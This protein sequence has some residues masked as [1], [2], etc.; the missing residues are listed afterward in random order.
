M[1][2]GAGGGTAQTEGPGQL[3]LLWSHL[4]MGKDRD[5]MVDGGLK[6]KL[7]LVVVGY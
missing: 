6:V 3:I 4:I 5:R 7:G 1:G 2:G